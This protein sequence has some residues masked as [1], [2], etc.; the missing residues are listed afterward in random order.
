[1]QIFEL[2]SEVEIG[3]SQGTGGIQSNPKKFHST[4]LH[5]SVMILQRQK[6]TVLDINQDR[7]TAVSLMILIDIF[8]PDWSW[9]PSTGREL[10]RADWGPSKA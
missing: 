10:R 8:Q 3:I 1:M 9:I 2:V 6:Q 5:S 4:L 7:E